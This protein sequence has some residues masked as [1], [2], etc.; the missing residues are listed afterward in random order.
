MDVGYGPGERGGADYPPH[1]GD[2]AEEQHEGEEELHGTVPE[3]GPRRDRTPL[4]SDGTHLSTMVPVAAYFVPAGGQCGYRS[5]GGSGRS[6]VM[7]VPAPA[8]L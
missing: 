6:T 3:G 4:L 8:A 1:D 5:A 2:H 7:C